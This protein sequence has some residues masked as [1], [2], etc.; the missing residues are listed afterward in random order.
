MLPRLVMAE[1]KRFCTAPKELRNLSTFAKASSN[2]DNGFVVAKAFKSEALSSAP[3]VA[4]LF[5]ILAV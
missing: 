2:L 5:V 1:S 3:L 4:V